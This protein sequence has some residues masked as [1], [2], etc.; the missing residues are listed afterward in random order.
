MTVK[1]NNP[2][3]LIG[4]DKHTP[5]KEYGRNLLLWIKDYIS[6]KVNA[7]AGIYIW[8]GDDRIEKIF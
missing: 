3:H 8:N 5:Y 2:L 6:S 4:V 1:T 7:A